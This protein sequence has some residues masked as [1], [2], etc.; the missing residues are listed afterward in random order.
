MESSNE[1]KEPQL[2]LKN[3]AT[4]FGDATIEHLV[5]AI[6]NVMNDFNKKVKLNLEK[7]LKGLMKDWRT[8]SLAKR[9][10]EVNNHLSNARKTQEIIEP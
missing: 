5:S 4:S 9:Y 10:K 1:I 7:T 6:Q 3:V 2:E 8:S